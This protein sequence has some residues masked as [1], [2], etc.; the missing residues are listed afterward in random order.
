L[1]LTHCC[2]CLFNIHKV[3]L[4]AFLHSALAI[5]IKR[6]VS[7]SS[8]IWRIVVAC[9]LMIMIVPW[10]LMTRFPQS[11]M[12]LSQTWCPYWFG[13]DLFDVIHRRSLL[14]ARRLWCIPIIDCIHV[15]KTHSWS[16]G[17]E[18]WVWLLR[19]LLQSL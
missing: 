6:D 4:V 5:H 18:R 7:R 8:L 3:A 15:P 16:W 12:V 17:P 14:I 2:T 1:L 11:H 19:R 9:I 10:R 13:C